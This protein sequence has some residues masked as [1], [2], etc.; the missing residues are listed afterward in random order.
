MLQ[1]SAKG[2]KGKP[3]TAFP[4]NYFLDNVDKLD[5][6]RRI[7]AKPCAS[8]RIWCSVKTRP[9]CSMPAARK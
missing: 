2:T 1:L 5:P 9:S 4:L 7:K 8:R 3:D 6:K